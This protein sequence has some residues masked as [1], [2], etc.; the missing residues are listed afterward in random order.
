MTKLLLLFVLLKV[1]KLSAETALSFFNR[2]Y[3]SDPFKQEGAK[4][5]LEIADDEF[6]KIVSYTKDKFSFGLI[7]SW[8]NVL[9]LLVFILMGGFTFLESAAVRTVEAWEGGPVLLGLVFWAYLG[10]VSFAWELPF[11]L[12]FTFR[13][14][15]KHGFNRQTFRGFLF[16]KVKSILLGIILGAT[17][18]SLVLL[19][20]EEG[21]YWW[22][23]A[24]GVTSSFGILVSWIYP[25]LLAPIFNKF[26]PLPDGDLKEQ[27]KTLAANVQFRLGDI[28]IMDASKRSA[29]GNAY[30]TGLFGKK[31]IVLFDTL[32]DSLSSKEIV[33]VLAH[34]LGHFKLNHVR[35]GLIRSIALMGVIFYAMSLVKPLLPFYDAFGL[36]GV[37]NYAAL[38][39]FGL[40]YG[41]VDFFFTP[42]MSWMSRRNE[43]AADAFAKRHMR[44]HEE[45]AQALVKLQKKNQSMP[46]SHPA[47]SR[48]YYSHPPLL[49]RLAAL[50]KS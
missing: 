27:I 41:I 10:A 44:G 26:T 3:Y 11:E 25:S 36:S 32:V 35:G 34:E 30:F 23:W 22:L 43:F 48:F 38:L 42:I 15:E 47:F 24:W 19:V 7:S 20:M 18:L 4:R 2:V 6:A 37:S 8:M 50:Q 29:H 46:L 40:W 13:V 49:E 31:R 39:V 1:A 17:F 12:Y 5:T 28:F 45:L 33:A 21:S 16:D 9:V 14:E